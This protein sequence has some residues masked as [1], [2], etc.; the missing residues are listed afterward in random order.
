GLKC[1]EVCTDYNSTEGVFCDTKAE[2]QFNHLMWW[3]SKN[4]K[5]GNGTGDGNIFSTQSGL[6]LNYNPFVQ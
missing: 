4:F 5:E 3:T 6:I 2:C 1:S